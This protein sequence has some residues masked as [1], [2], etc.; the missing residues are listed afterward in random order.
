MGRKSSNKTP[1]RKHMLLNVWVAEEQVKALKL[2]AKAKQ[3]N[4]SAIVR[5]ML[6]DWFAEVKHMK[7]DLLADIIVNVQYKWNQEKGKR[8]MSL[9]DKELVFDTFVEKVKEEYA[10]LG[11]NTIDFIIEN[12]RI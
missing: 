3:A 2:Y 5:G 4:V 12:I 11:E 10:D 7:N 8:I 9:E 6:E 1:K